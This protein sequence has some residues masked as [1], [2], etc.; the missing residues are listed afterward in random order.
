MTKKENTIEVKSFR[1]Y[2]YRKLGVDSCVDYGYSHIGS[3][4]RQDKA[5]YHRVSLNMENPAS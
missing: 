1:V 3:V 2:N 5:S 4:N